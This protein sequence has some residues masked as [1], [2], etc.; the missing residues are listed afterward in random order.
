MHAIDEEKENLSRTIRTGWELE[1]WSH[2]DLVRALVLH[3]L[4][5]SSD[6]N[7]SVLFPL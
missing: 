6:L 2:D 4:L 3:V 7:D 1:H 5:L